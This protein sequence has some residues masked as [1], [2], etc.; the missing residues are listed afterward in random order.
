[1]FQFG[2]SS[3]VIGSAAGKGDKHHYIPVFYLKQWA[4]PDQRVCEYSRPYKI[5]KP[6]RVHPDGT[7]YVRGLY[8]VPG[9]EPNVAEFIEREFLKPTDS[10]ASD[11]LRLLLTGQQIDWTTITRS[12]WSRFIIS[13]MLRNPSMWQGW[14]R[15]LP[16]SSAPYLRNSM[17]DTGR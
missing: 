5:V 1:M 7:G 8:T 2:A 13:L 9:A 16:R 10:V 4:G 17:N 11:V 15:K 3:L 12:A 14:E 6:K